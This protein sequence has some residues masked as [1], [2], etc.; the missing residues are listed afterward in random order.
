[1]EGESKLRLDED[2]RKQLK[3][4][5]AKKELVTQLEAGVSHS[6]MEGGILDKLVEMEDKAAKFKTNKVGMR[7]S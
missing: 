1:M 5:A 7:L 6:M 4:L 3:V 2:S